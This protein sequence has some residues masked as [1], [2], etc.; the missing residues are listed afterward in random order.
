MAE[1]NGGEEGSEDDPSSSQAL[2]W[3]R[4]RECGV[5][6]QALLFVYLCSY[7]AIC[8]DLIMRQPSSA[9]LGRVRAE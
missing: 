3:K 5:C 4:G 1:L 9:A 8:S 2:C 6:S 7:W